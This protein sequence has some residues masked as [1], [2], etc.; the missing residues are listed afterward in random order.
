MSAIE[1]IDDVLE[2]NPKSLVGQSFLGGNLPLIP[3]QDEQLALYRGDFILIFDW[4]H[5]VL[6]VIERE[7]LWTVTTL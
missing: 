2:V 5:T 6:E 4:S 1:F 7:R 3:I